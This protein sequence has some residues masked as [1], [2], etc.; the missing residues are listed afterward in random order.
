MKRMIK[1]LIF[2]LLAILYFKATVKQLNLDP[3]LFSYNA[4]ENKVDMNLIDM[5]ELNWEAID[6]WDSIRTDKL[7]L[8]GAM[9]LIVLSECVPRL[10]KQQDKEEPEEEEPD[11]EEIKDFEIKRALKRI[12]VKGQNIKLPLA[13]C[14]LG[15][16]FTWKKTDHA[17]LRSDGTGAV[18]IYFHDEECF[19]TVAENYYEGAEDQGMIYEIRIKTDDCSI[20]GF[21]P[22]KTTKQEVI[23]RYGKRAKLSE[24]TNIYVYY[25]TKDSDLGPRLAIEFDQND[26]VKE[27]FINI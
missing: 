3:P 25:G 15:E 9:F 19:H 24:I 12:I 13:L 11:V 23:E 10:G 27:I 22:G 4:A 2:V 26:V 7:V 14:D 20:D 1:L 5:G 18:T 17:S 8:L 21:V 16:G 6:S